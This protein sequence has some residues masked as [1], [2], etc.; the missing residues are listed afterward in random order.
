M[1][2]RHKLSDKQWNKIKDNLF[3][4][5]GKWGGVSMVYFVGIFLWIR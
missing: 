2:Y 1:S 5:R 3:D 4:V